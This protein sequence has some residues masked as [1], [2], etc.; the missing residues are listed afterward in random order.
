MEIN[1]F[2]VLAKHCFLTGKNSIQAKDW[3]DKC[4]GD[5]APEDTNIINWYAEFKRD[6]KETNDVKTSEQLIQGDDELLSQSK[7]NA[8]N[9]TTTVNAES[10]GADESP[11]TKIPK[12]TTRPKK[13]CGPKN[14]RSS[15]KG[16]GKSKATV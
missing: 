1:E 10:D 7:N 3:L 8:K 11:P 14:G 9:K 6:Y 13:T 16:R 12:K 4:Y 15:G 2:R 5:S